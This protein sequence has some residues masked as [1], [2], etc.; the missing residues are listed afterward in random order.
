MKK[1][2]INFL[3]PR[4][5]STLRDAFEVSFPYWIIDEKY[6]GTP[7]E[8]HQKKFYK[9]TVGI[10][11]RM[12]AAW[13]AQDKDFDILKILYEFGKRQIIQKLKDH[14]L[15][16]NEELII[17]SETHPNNCP[18]DSTKIKGPN[19]EPIIIEIPDEPI[20]KTS[21]FNELA[22]LIIDTRDNINTLFHSL[23]KDKLLFIDQERDLLQL[24]R[25]AQT[26][27]EFIFRITALRNII[28]NINS[29]VLVRIIND[30]QNES[31]TIN[32]FE[33][34]L[35]FE[36]ANN[37]NEAIIK[38]YRHINR[39]RMSYPIHSDQ[40]NGVLDALKYFGLV[41]PIDEFTKA[42]KA[43][44]IAYKISLVE[45]LDLFKNKVFV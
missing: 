26:P 25:D 18:F 30:N 31:K 45:L 10:T 27:E 40:V 5:L 8:K 42:W 2:V 3:Q 37:Y 7:E 11:G 38:T 1:F 34:Y 32:L 33:Q 36:F 28:I 39:L 44:L 20:M 43:I 4:E 16:S 21:E 13:R 35:R 23:H 24:F 9:I 41:Y 12:D 19:D 29:I 22:A 15:Q 17:S 6:I 14:T